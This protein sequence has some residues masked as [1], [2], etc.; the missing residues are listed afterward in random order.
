MSKEH[1]DKQGKAA[2]GVDRKERQGG[3]RQEGAPSQ[4][5]ESAI[6]QLQQTVGNT[7]VQT[8]LVQRK[9]QGAHALEEETAESIRQAKGESGEKLDPGTAQRASQ[10][11]GH[12]MQGVNIHT[13]SQ[14]DDLTRQVGAKAFTTGND[15]FFREGEYAP[16]TQAGQQ[17]IGHEL[18]HVAQQA[19]GSQQVAPKLDDDKANGSGEQMTVNDPGDKYEAEADRMAAQFVAGGDK[20]T[21]VSSAGGGDTAVQASHEEEEAMQMQE[22][23]EEQMQMQEDEEEQMQ[24]QEEEEEVQMQELEE[25]ETDKVRL[26]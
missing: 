1:L 15:V 19:G 18:T 24:M 25:E 23:E 6:T 12:N 4:L 26:P 7:A 13:D 20:A 14:A 3:E 17:L 21:P 22:D 2:V 5:N 11:M 10:V 16:E 9:A 8:L